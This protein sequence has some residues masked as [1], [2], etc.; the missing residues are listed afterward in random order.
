[1]SDF[2]KSVHIELDDVEKMLIAKNKAY[3]NSALE[4]CRVFSK[5]SVKEQLL[6]RIDDKLSRIRNMGFGDNGEDTV[7]DLIGYLVLLRLAMKGGGDGGG[8]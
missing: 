5:A 1:M 3:G 4:P 7:K 8:R 2:G 6:V